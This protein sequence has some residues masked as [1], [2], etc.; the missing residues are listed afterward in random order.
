MA[1]SKRI[2]ALLE[3]FSEGVVKHRENMCED[4]TVA[5]RAHGRYTKALEELCSLGEAGISAFARLMDSPRPVVRV[6]AAIFLISFYP[7]RAI[8]I[9]EAET[10][11]GRMS[12]EALVAL[13]RWKRGT[14]LDPATCREVRRRPSE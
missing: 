14:Y 7:D 10:T 9:L 13:E 2:E 11:G 6:S 3:Q 8:K 5:N 1:D 12:P 4:S